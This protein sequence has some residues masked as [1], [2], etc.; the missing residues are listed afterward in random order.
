M[1]TNAGSLPHIRGAA[2]LHYTAAANG[3]LWKNSVAILKKCAKKYYSGKKVISSHERVFRNTKS[4]KE[5]ING[6]GNEDE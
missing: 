1:K 4:N 3:C 2:D 5:M 6:M